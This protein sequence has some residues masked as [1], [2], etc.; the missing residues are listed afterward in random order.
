MNLHDKKNKRLPF[1]ELM[2]ALAVVII[3]WINAALAFSAIHTLSDNHRRVM[4]SGQIVAWL[5]DLNLALLAAESGQRGY[6]LTQ[7]EAYLSPYHSVLEN[8]DIRIEAVKKIQ[9]ESASQDKKIKKLL[10]LSQE[11]IDQLK[12]TVNL[13]LDDK[14][15]RAI[16]FVKTGEGRELSLGIATI[17]QELYSQEFGFQ[18]TLY[19]ET[20][21]SER[22]S[23]V[24]FFVSLSIS[25]LLLVG[26]LL[27]LR[28][29][30]KKE[31]IHRK[32]I[33][34]KALEL[35][36]KIKERTKELTLYSEQLARSNQ[37]LEDFAFVASHDLQEPL[38][39]I[40]TFSSR[41]QSIYQ[42]ALD[43]KGVDYLRR[44]N[45]AAQRMSAL[46][47]DL[48]EFSRIKTQGKDFEKIDLNHLVKDVIDDLEIA[49]E[50][51]QAHISLAK[52]PEINADGSQMN[53]LFIN[54]LSNAIKFRRT[55]CAPSIHISYQLVSTSIADVSLQCHQFT[56][57]DNGIGFDN[58]Y[59][60]KIFVPFQRLHGR[61]EYKGTGIGLAVCRKIVERHGGTI[62]AESE[63]GK[64]TKFFFTLPLQTIDFDRDAKKIIE[65]GYTL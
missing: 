22:D 2:S 48:L 49:I 5:K 14:E 54:I 50:T 40:R 62:W 58:R 16:K 18:E 60:D 1:L 10:R 35:E 4:Y 8:L 53:Q 65:E 6:L 64:G 3:I 34:H 11:K 20:K 61:D 51:S 21:V 57:E 44:L 17:L 31:S 42:D 45:N 46:I 23:R 30:Y 26:V 25:T 15:N 38:R 32:E 36:D 37:E 63:V 56:I 7:K 19:Q 52:L 41:I 43:E 9:A 59:I 29:N 47:S 13:A 55:D 12:Q 28:F 33:E 39:K 27:L 24:L